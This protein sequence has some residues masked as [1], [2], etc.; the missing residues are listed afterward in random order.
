[1]NSL[2]SLAKG[3]YLE[4]LLIEQKIRAARGNLLDFTTFTKKN[5]NV[6]WH[7]ELICQKL[8]EF[9]AGNIRRLVIS[10]PPRNGKT[11]LVSRRLPAYLFGKDPE[12]QIIACSYGADLAQHNNRDVQRII[13]SKEYAAVFPDTY[14]ND[15][16]VR[17]DAH[18]SYIRN[19]DTFEIVGH[20]GA[21]NCSGIGGAITGKGM[22]YGIVDDYHKNREE[23]ESPTMRQKVWDWYQD[24][25]ATR[26]EGEGSILVTATR[27][28][29]DDLIGRLLKK[30]KDDPDADQWEVITLP[31]LSEEMLEPYDQ[32]TGPDQPL[33]PWKFSYEWLKKKKANLTTYSWLSLY[34]QRPVALSGNLVSESSFKYCS[35]NGGLLTLKDN[36]NDALN[37]TYLLSQCRI[38]QTCDP[39]ASEKKTADFFSLGTWAQTPFNEIALIDLVHERMEKPKQLPLM[40]QQYHNWHPMTQWVATKGLGISLFQDLRA[41]GLPV[42]KIEE[43][44]DKVSRFI[45]ACNHIS[46]GTVYFL[47]N[48]PHKAE[49][50]EQLLDF[51]KGDH[52]DMVDV[53]SMAVYAA[54]NYPY[55]I[56][57]Y[58]TS[59]VGGSVATGGMRI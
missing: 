34:Q 24:V 14:L 51:P 49:Y 22:N 7:H 33:W 36:F 20:S 38:F 18:G 27:W 46:A 5:Y 28:H 9:I 42:N 43:E 25:F 47:D 54:I 39:A 6:N 57:Q 12:A 30:A 1:M 17:T 44:S 26:E 53:T 50:K 59:Y 52:D 11:E 21:Y 40:R 3:T 55:E 41:N 15:S 19:S 2:S 37:K 45:T 58:E 8:D 4:N 23:A 13:D 16:N 48:L 31:A 35:L 56:Q 29:K 32:R 10:V